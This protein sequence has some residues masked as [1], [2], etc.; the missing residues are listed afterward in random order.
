MCCTNLL[1]LQEEALASEL[2]GRCLFKE[3][4]F[5]RAQVF[6]AH[7][8]EKYQSWGAKAIVR[9]LGI[10]MQQKFS[11][12][13]SVGRG[14]PLNNYCVGVLNDQDDSSVSRKRSAA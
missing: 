13:P 6:Y 2:A 11:A 9:R 4:M 8:I 1:A 12:M 14:L 10:E 3:G 5:D 7:A